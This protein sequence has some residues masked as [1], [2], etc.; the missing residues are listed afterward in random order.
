MILEYSSFHEHT[1]RTQLGKHGM[2]DCVRSERHETDRLHL[3]YHLPTDV[4]LND[5]VDLGADQEHDCFLAVA[6]EDG[7]RVL[8]DAEASS[9]T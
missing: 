4:S 9:S 7:K 3:A 8:V 5:P 6:P 1:L 2:M